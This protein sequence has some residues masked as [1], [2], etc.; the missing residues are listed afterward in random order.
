MSR[1]EIEKKFL[2]MISG[3]MVVNGMIAMPE[4]SLLTPYKRSLLIYAAT[5]ATY[6]ELTEIVD[7]INRLSDEEFEKFSTIT[8]RLLKRG[9]SGR[10]NE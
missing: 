3:Y 5:C 1:L 2:Y 10:K 8:E 4:D 9:E 6:C 7:V